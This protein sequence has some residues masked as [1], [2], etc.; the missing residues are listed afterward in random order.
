MGI[1]WAIVRN[2]HRV[3]RATQSYRGTST[4]PT[5]PAQ[6]NPS[7]IRSETFITPKTGNSFVSV[8]ILVEK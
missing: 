6:E 2:S 4:T 8:L 5:T 3:S 7:D 1:L